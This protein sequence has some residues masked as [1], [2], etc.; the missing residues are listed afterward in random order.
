M[1]GIRIIVLFLGFLIV[2]Q[3]QGKKPRMKDSLHIIMVVDTLHYDEFYKKAKTW[4]IGRTKKADRIILN[5]N[6]PIYLKNSIPGYY[7][8]CFWT[9]DLWKKDK[10]KW[11][12]QQLEHL[13]N[14]DV[15]IEAMVT[16]TPHEWLL[17]NGYEPEID[18][19]GI[20]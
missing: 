17:K 7:A 12:E 19:L 16:L 11:L 2:W 6:A 3:M 14:K 18:T 8:Y 10:E 4:E 1:K 5:K 15:N 13:W 20:E 9:S